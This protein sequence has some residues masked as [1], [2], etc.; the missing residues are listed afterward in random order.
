MVGQ[1]YTA[2]PGLALIDGR[3]LTG[4]GIW[5]TALR[6]MER[7]C[8]GAWWGGKLQPCEDQVQERDLQQVGTG[9][10]AKVRGGSW[11]EPQHDGGWQGPLKI[12]QTNP[13]ARGASPRAACTGS[14]P[15]EFEISPEEETP[16]GQ[17]RKRRK[18][19]SV[20]ASSK[21]GKGN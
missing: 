9:Q 2:S 16:W 13:P 12:I 11:A 3:A 4:G 18:S 8:V 10:G 17:E 15:G 6:Q 19:C 7:G 14:C 20:K 21:E 1:I 5:S